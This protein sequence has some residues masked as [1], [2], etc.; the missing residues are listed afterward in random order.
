M[1]ILVCFRYQSEN[2]AWKPSSNTN[3][4]YLEH[5]CLKYTANFST[6]PGFPSWQTVW[7]KTDECATLE[8][9][10]QF[11]LSDNNTWAPCQS[12]S[13][14]ALLY[15]VSQFYNCSLCLGRAK[16][17]SFGIC[18]TWRTFSHLFVGYF[19]WNECRFSRAPVGIT[20]AFWSV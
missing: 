20:C 9:K 5:I 2:M 16:C 17:I 13:H 1:I 15:S 4:R 7:I 6:V 10:L 11:P 14:A 18:I 12:L 19:F 8:C 3:P